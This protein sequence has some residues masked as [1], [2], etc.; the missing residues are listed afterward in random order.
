MLNPQP[1]ISVIIPA[2]NE[3][4][5]IKPTLDSYNAYLK[6]NYNKYQI[7]VISDGSTDKTCEIVNNFSKEEDSI[8]LVDLVFNRGKGFAVRTGMLHGKG[9]RL[10]FADA[11]GASPIEELARLEQAI[12]EGA[13]VAIGSRAKISKE[14]KIKT[15]LHRKVIGRIFNG[16]V[17]FLAVPHI[18]DTQCGFKLFTNEACKLVFSKQ[19]STGFSF[20]VEI[21]MIAQRTGLKISEVPINWV[22]VPGSKVNLVTDSIKMF[23]D[24]IKF[25]YWHHNLNPENLKNI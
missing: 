2:Y 3:E 11:D 15:A 20:D 24:I 22:N 23:I 9:K 10:I 16:L 14:T 19:L 25:R 7:I 8:Q 18:E 1:E 4:N 13:D 21:L 5:R 6:Q 17:N 12:N